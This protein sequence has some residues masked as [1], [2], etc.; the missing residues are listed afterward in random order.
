VILTVIILLSIYY[1]DPQG[2]PPSKRSR[3]DVSEPSAFGAS[4]AGPSSASGLDTKLCEWKSKESMFFP[5]Q[6]IL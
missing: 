3:L 5:P 2:P 4:T 1:T 6:Y